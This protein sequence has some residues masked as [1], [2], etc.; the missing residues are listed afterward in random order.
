MKLREVF[1]CGEGDLFFGIPLKAHNLYTL[2]TARCAE[3][4]RKTNPSHTFSHTGSFG[5]AGG[6]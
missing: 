3:S 5:L 6:A 1:W 4:A 2:R